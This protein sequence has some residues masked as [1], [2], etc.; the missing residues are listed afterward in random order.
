MGF[1]IEIRPSNCALTIEI[2]SSEYFLVLLVQN[3][4]NRLFET[5]LLN[6][7][8]TENTLT[9]FSVNNTFLVATVRIC[10]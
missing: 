7:Q 10:H 6:L 9:N 8:Y 4:L 3:A 5:H 2:V 1:C